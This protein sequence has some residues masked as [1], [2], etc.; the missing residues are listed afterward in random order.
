VASAASTRVLWLAYGQPG[1]LFPVAPLIEHLVGRGVEVVLVGPEAL[2]GTARSVGVAFRSYRGPIAYDWSRRET[3]DRHEFGPAADST[4][5]ARRVAAEY[6]E[7]LDA[8]EHVDPH[9]LLCD[10]FV[11][12]GGLA[13]EGI[14]LPWASYVHYL[15]DEG[16]QLDA[17][18]QIWWEGTSS[19]PREAYLAW[20]DAIRAVVGLGPETRPRAVAPWYR[21]SPQLTFLLGHPQLR[22]GNLPLPPGVTR[23]SFPPWDGAAPSEPAGT[24]GATSSRTGPGTGRTTGRSGAPRVLVTNSTAWQDDL[25]LVRVAL[26]A[27]A[28]LD[29]RLLVTVAADHDLDVP[30]PPNAEVVGFLPHTQALPEV[31]AVVSTAGYGLVSKALWWGKPL[32][33]APRGRD[34]FYVADAVIAQGCGLRLDWPPDADRLRSAVLNAAGA[35]PL[36]DRATALSGARPGFPGPAEAAAMVTD[37]APRNGGRGHGLHRR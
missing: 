11:I 37:L 8:V 35:G 21:M 33:L 7:V 12:G 22:R 4:W 24:D 3:R 9:V 1:G 15:F 10:S 32:V 29:L 34:Q 17:L 16:A 20:W 19:Q 36:R 27:L 26:T 13:A 2:R 25:D 6:A 14:G 31:D 30:V 18:H 5:F 23:T 28:G